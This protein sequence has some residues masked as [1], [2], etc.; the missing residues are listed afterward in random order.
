MGLSATVTVGVAAAAATVGVGFAAA[1][2]AGVAAAP[3]P[4]CSLFFFPHVRHVSFLKACSTNS[5]LP[6]LPLLLLLLETGGL[7]LFALELKLDPEGAGA[8]LLEFDALLLA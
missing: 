8:G 1:A 2:G 6:P 5:Q 3:A 7:L 4:P